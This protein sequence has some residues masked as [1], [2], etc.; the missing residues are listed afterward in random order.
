[1]S[2]IPISQLGN[3]IAQYWIGFWP[4]A[5]K[6]KKRKEEEKIIKL[7]YEMSALIQS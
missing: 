1:M 3:R 4:G 6:K 5:G 2:G 7:N